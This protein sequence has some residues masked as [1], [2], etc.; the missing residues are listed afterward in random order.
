MNGIMLNP[1]TSTPGRATRDA[2]SYRAKHTGKDN[3]ASDLFLASVPNV[4]LS[5]K[6]K[7]RVYNPYNYPKYAH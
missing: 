3:F 5:T 6:I 7:K 1:L 2:L 4:S